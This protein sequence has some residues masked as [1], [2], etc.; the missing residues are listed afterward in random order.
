LNNFLT[1]G[2]VVLRQ[3]LYGFSQVFFAIDVVSGENRVG[4]PT[5]QPFRCVPT[6]TAADHVPS[7]T[8]AKVMKD[9]ADAPSLFAGRRPGFPELANAFPAAMKNQILRKL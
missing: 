9:L 7:S 6:H 1:F 4:L 8:S 5:A 3:Q 2:L